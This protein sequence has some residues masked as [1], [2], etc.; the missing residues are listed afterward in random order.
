MKRYEE[1][2]ERAYVTTSGDAKHVM[3]G[4]WVGDPDAGLPIDESW[5]EVEYVRSDLLVEAVDRIAALERERDELAFHGAIKSICA[6]SAEMRTLAEWKP[7][8]DMAV[9]A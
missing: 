7:E 4:V 2:P 8:T 9:E 3:S 5:I 1:W 6:L